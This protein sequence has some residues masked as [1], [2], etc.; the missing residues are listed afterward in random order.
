MAQDGADRINFLT[1]KFISFAKP[2]LMSEFGVSNSS[3]SNVALRS[4]QPEVYNLILRGNDGHGFYGRRV[5]RNVLGLGVLEE[6]PC[7]CG[8]V[9]RATA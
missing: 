6:K 4:N 7:L 2:V 9:K 8:G 5:R 3:D 1:K